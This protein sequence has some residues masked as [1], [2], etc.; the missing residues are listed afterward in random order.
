LADP[1]LERFIGVVYRPDTE[2]QSHYMYASLPRQFDAFLWF[3]R[4]TAVTP[5][6]EERPASGVS[7]TFPF[8]L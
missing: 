5:V 7:E 2:R 6:G 8:G 1:R 4:T 3:D